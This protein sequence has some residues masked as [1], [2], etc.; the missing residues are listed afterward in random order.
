MKES[1]YK[2]AS[3]P[4]CVALL[5]DLHNRPCTSVL[6]SLERK[7][8]TLI[9]VTGDFVYGG[10]PDGNGLIVELQRNVLSFFSGCAAVAP[11]F[12]S[13][14][15]HEQL[16]SS[17]DLERIRGTGA[18]ILENSF[19]SVPVGR[20]VVNVGGLSSGYFTAIQRLR[21]TDPSRYPKRDGHIE[22][23]PDLS[24]LSGFAST[25]GF[26]ILLSHHPGYF[27]TIPSSID[28]VLSGHA[29]G[30]QWR[31]FNHG[32]FAP[33]Q[34]LWPKYTKGLYESRLIVSA[35]LSN[36]AGIPRFF[37]PTEIVYIDPAPA[38]RV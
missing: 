25:T 26:K 13:L 28:L 7:K 24:W 3:L 21:Q 22:H 23:N 8:P 32:V 14:G 20:D 29:H 11:T 31:I 9:C 10:Y 33:G 17:D 30:G 2:V 37:N 16:L 19:V 38:S 35:G 15:N 27:P 4:C 5:S 12:V 1:F 34:G 36:T 6:A 18:V